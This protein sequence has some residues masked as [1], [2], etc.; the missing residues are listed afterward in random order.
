MSDTNTKNEPKDTK[1]TKPPV[2]RCPGCGHNFYHDQPRVDGRCHYCHEDDAQAQTG[3]VMNPNH[4]TL[5]QSLPLYLVNY[6]SATALFRDTPLAWELYTEHEK[7]ASWGDN[8]HTLLTLKRVRET[9]EEA[10]QNLSDEDHLA[11]NQ[12]SQIQTVFARLRT[13]PEETFIDLET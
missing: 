1:E 9:L 4:P 2:P 5:P 3:E 6:T 8:N 7:K 13:I 12:F 11:A 10:I